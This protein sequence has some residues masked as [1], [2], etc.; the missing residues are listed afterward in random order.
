MATL[1]ERIQRLEDI[2]AIK[3]LKNRYARM[4]NDNHNWELIPTIFAPDC[5]WIGSPDDPWGAAHSREDFV[6]LFKGFQKQMDGR[7]LGHNITNGVIEISEDGKHATGHWHLFGAYKMLGGHGF[8]EQGYYDY[9]YVKLEDGKW[10]IKTLRF[11]DTLVA[12]PAKGW[13]KVSELI[14]GDLEEATE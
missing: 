14:Q 4:C 3:D 6:E 7:C 2:A 10:Y 8:L 13:D 9:D 11:K 12:N 1:E 5:E